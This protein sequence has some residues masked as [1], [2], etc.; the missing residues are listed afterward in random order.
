TGGKHVVQ[1]E[2]AD[3][4]ADQQDAG[5]QGQAATAGDRQCHP[6]AA[7][8]VLLMGPEADQQEGYQAGQLP[9][10]QHQQQVTGQH[11]AQHGALEAQQQGIEFADIF[12]GFQV[13]AGIDDDQ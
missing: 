11:N 1:F 2:A 8:G 6:R 3:D 5:Q 10:N 12:L 4:A 9:E 7:T 13:I